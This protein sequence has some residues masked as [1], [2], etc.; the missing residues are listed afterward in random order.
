[1]V[2]TLFDNVVPPNSVERFAQKSW[3]RLRRGNPL[4]SQYIRDV[5]LITDVTPNALTVVL[6]PRVKYNKGWIP[7]KSPFDATLAK[8]LAGKDLKKIGDKW[9][10]KKNSFSRDGYLI[11]AGLQPKDVDP[12]DPTEM[13]F[14][15]FMNCD[16]LS[17]ATAKLTRRRLEWASVQVGDR[18]RIGGTGEF[19]SR[20]G[21]VVELVDTEAKVDLEKKFFNNI[22]LPW[23]CGIVS[24][25][26]N[27]LEKVF[28][29]GDRV[30]IRDG[31]LS[32]RMA[33]VVNVLEELVQVFLTEDDEKQAI[34]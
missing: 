33:W 28:R 9:E 3:V 30:R 25:M 24:V 4:G 26:I 15:S 2:N 19:S 29:V 11:L 20:T 6:L 10:F 13:E 16:A 21:N 8:Q 32:S 14:N 18:V 23:E 31:D 1:V 34:F 5:A 22:E 17:A 12:T 27:S 7:Q